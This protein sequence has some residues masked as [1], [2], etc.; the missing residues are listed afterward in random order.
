MLQKLLSNSVNHCKDLSQN[1]ENIIFTKLKLYQI[2]ND[3][4]LIKEWG[5]IRKKL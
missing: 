3:D 2:Y 5:K 1:V 4:N